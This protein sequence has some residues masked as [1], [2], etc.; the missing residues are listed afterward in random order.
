MAMSRRIGTSWA[1]EE[2][3]CNLGEL[4]LGLGAWDGQCDQGKEQ[5]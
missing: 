1:L 3:L 5:E 4:C 2:A